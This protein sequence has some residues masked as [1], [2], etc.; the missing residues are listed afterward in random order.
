MSQEAP[1]R[2]PPRFRAG[3]RYAPSPRS[4][5]PPRRGLPALAVRVRAFNLGNGVIMS[6]G[7]VAALLIGIAMLVLPAWLAWYLI[8]RWRRLATWPRAQATIRHVRKTKHNSSATGTTTSETSY[9]AR[10]EYPD[11]AG[12][13]HIGEVDHLAKPKVGDVVEII[14]DPND[15]KTNETV[16]GGS[17][18]GRIVNYSAVFIVFGGI[19]TFLVLASFGLITG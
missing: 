9:E 14:Y 17:V 11:A 6:L 13:Q 16:S 19:G 15:P 3:I 5:P 7:V 8:R 10:Y 12:V 4:A 2:K 18:V 1:Q